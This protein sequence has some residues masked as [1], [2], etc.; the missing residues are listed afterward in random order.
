[1]SDVACVLML[2]T[3]VEVLPYRMVVR[4]SLVKLPSLLTSDGRV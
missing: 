2:E 1:M 4:A 3:D